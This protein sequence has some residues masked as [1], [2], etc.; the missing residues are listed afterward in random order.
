MK[1]ALAPLCLVAACAMAS[2]ASATTFVFD[3]EASSIT[4]T[5][6]GGGCLLGSCTLTASFAAA[7]TD[8][9][10]T[11]AAAG[12]S[13][14]VDDFIDWSILTTKWAIGGGLYDVAVNLVFSSPTMASGSGTG[15][16]GFIT[17][18]GALSGG[19]LSWDGGGQGSITFADGSELGYDLEGTLVGGLG[20]STT[21]G[22]TFAANALAPVPVPASALLLLGGLA[23]LAA[24]NRRKS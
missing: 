9:S 2:A 13:I 6:L 22:V 21:T 19:Y 23:G 18:L 17:L 5:S 15:S 20:N 10:W 12:D 16:A 11:P 7:A 14:E 8:W 24:A 1:H 3:E 4:L